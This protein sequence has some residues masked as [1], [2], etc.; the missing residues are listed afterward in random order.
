MFRGSLFL[1][2]P[3]GGGII[4]CCST[5]ALTHWVIHHWQ[6]DNSAFLLRLAT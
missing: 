3:F 1:F 6:S 4:T 2:K 5:N